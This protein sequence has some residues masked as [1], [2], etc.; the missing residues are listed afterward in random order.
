MAQNW[1]R[2]DLLE[3]VESYAD[4]Y[5]MIASESELS[6]L[7]DSDIAPLVIAEYGESDS[8]AMNEAFNNWSDGLCKNGEIHPEQYSQ[9]CYVG[10]WSD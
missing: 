3:L 1:N 9:Y 10:K 4:E 8:V 7:F 5:G 6:E 2:I